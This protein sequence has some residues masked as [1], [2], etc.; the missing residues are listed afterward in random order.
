MLLYDSPNPA[1]NPRRVRIFM[2]E[3]GISLPTSTVDIMKREQKAPEYR[4]LNPLGQVPTLVLDDGT[5][6]SETVAICRYL[7]ETTPGDSLF[8]TT[9]Q[10]RACVEMWIRRVEFVL[11]QPVGG[12]W[13]HAHPR[14]AAL[15]TQYKDYGESNR[16]TYAA[17]VRFFDREL[18]DR[19]FIAGPRYSM[20]DICALT[21][22]DFAELIGLG[23][24]E[25][26]DHFS[27]WR[28]AVSARPSA[29]A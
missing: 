26:L 23:P 2:A 21:T 1:P 7:D 3:R 11:M 4:A 27:R 9:P 22:V 18:M 15:L 19:A 28:A 12:F 13:R 14:T 17:A 10:E 6:I 24:P 25:G 8:G 20:A 29:A 16:E 5:A